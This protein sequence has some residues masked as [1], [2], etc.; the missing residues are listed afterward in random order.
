[1]TEVR[2][3]VAFAGGGSGGHLSPGLAI[4]ERMVEIVPGVR[5]VFLCSTRAID[6]QMLGDA[7]VAFRPIPAEGFAASPRGVLRFV[8]GYVKGVL[9]ARRVLRDEGVEHVVSLGGFVTGPVT[10]AARMLRIPITLVN[11]DATPG[12][13]NRVVA[14]RAQRVV[15]ACQTPGL[16]KFAEAI[17]GMPLR[18]SAVAQAGRAACRGELGLDP[19]RPTLLVTGASQGA[20]SLNAF[21]VAFALAHRDLL[22]DWQVLH[23]AGPRGTPSA[24]ELDAAYAR[25]GVKALVLVASCADST[26][27]APTRGL[28]VVVN[29]SSVQG[30]PT[31]DFV[32]S[33]GATGYQLRTGGEPVV[34]DMTGQTIAAAVDQATLRIMD[35]LH[36]QGSFSFTK[37]QLGAVSVKGPGGAL[38][39]NVAV[40][41][42]EV[43]GRNLQAFVGANGPYRTDTNKD[44]VINSGDA[45]DEDA[46]GLVIDQLTFGLGLYKVRQT[47]ANVLTGLIGT[48]FTALKAQGSKIGFVGVGDFIKFSLD[49][50]NVGINQSS[51]ATHVIDFT[52]GGLCG[53]R[54]AAQKISGLQHGDSQLRGAGSEGLKGAQAGQSGS[55]DEN[56][57]FGQ[58]R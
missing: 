33:F 22:K 20:S 45:I 58:L 28:D 44:G 40:D 39:R 46:V 42:F 15:S 56:I 37:G 23:L 27:A 19:V 53:A 51:K 8:R 18:R 35:F 31:L 21:M 13:A 41:G 25:A 57:H 52:D 54:T 29:Q 38:T 1:M 3:T 14:R 34:L 50:V 24:A 30:G 12:R 47:P 11:L 36:V 4:A 7:G 48:Q 43:G 9:Q 6:A 55:D 2:R 32:R 5:P 10:Q 49:D 17:V 16:P 26:V